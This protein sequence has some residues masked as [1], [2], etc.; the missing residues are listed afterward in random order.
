MG[1]ARRG[2]KAATATSIE[3]TFQYNGRRCR[4]RIPLPPTAANLDRAADHVAAIRHEIKQGTFDYKQV[5]PHSKQAIANAPTPGGRTLVA[6][7][8]ESWFE[9]TKPGLAASTLREWRGTVFNL[10][11]PKFGKLTLADL[12]RR[13]IK[14]WLVSL[15]VGRAKPLSNKRLANIQTVLRSALDDAVEA[16]ILDANPL[17]GYTYS[18]DLPGYDEDDEEDEIDPFDIEEQRL[19]LVACRTAQFRN[20]LQFAFWTGLRTSEIIAL[21]WK[22]VDWHRGTIRVRKALTRAAKGA[23]EK[24]KTAAGRREVKLLPPAREALE[25]QRA[26][27]QLKGEEIFQNPNMGGRIEGGPRR[28]RG[29]NEIW[30]IWQT[31]LRN[32]KVRYRNP[33]QTRHTFASMMLSAG[34]HPMWVAKQMGH[35]D[36]TMIARVYGHWMPDADRSAGERAVE[37]FASGMKMTGAGGDR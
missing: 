18:R 23:F 15:D 10:L 35:A 31:T 33:Y 29:D 6:D 11:I 32:A 16:E 37:K 34:E 4:E 22:D 1:R 3:I 9:E 17:A 36:W 25:A 27:T 28:W 14:S 21:N 5:F 26:L 30:R 2:V 19:I 7:Y 13:E 20:L 12:T 8:L 24:P